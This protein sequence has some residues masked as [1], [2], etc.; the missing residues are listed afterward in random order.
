MH[1]KLQELVDFTKE[2][3]SLDEFQLKRYQLFKEKDHN[4]ELSYIFNMEWFPTRS[5][6]E[7]DEFNPPGT[8]SIDVDFHTKRVKSLIFVDGINDLEAE[9]PTSDAPEMAIE[10]VENETGLEF[11]RQFKLENTEGPD[12]IF[13]AAVDNIP[14]YPSGYIE[15]E[16]NDEGKLSLFTMHGNFPDAEKVSWEP[17]ALT[18][19]ETKE[20]VKN[21]LT[22]L[23]IP[24]VDEEKW[25]KVYTISSSF[26]TNTTKEVLSYEEVETDPAHVLLNQ[27]LEW[28]NAE[29][30]EFPKKEIDQSTDA[31]V[32]EAL[33]NKVQGPAPLTDQEQNQVIRQV[34]AYLQH[35]KPED[36]GKWM[37]TSIQREDKYIY[38]V[39]RLNKP[40]L[41]VITRKLTVVLETDTLQPINHIDNQ[42]LLD[43]FQELSSAPEATITKDEAFDRLYKHI[44]ISP[45]YV[46]DK[47][48]E[49]YILC[50]KIDS[51][52]AIDAVTGDL[53]EMEA[54]N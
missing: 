35:I 22:L 3:F 6:D 25:Q 43:T 19:T 8:V 41:R 1:E 15:L 39:L 49:E 29:P 23:E 53:V 17:F 28:E 52:L 10:W 18:E 42:A 37:L 2:K 24:I 14:I 44:E 16:F 13:L 5:T 45:I 26:I 12:L 30:S 7:T 34:E 51:A 36:S 38:A 40:E 54:L 50:G 27:A 20:L 48:N 47:I 31:S 21:Q 46:Y 11:G 9:L 4:N 33:N 32:E